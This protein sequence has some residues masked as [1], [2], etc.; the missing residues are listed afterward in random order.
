[1]IGFGVQVR[2]NGRKSFTLDYRFEARRRRLF[3]GDFPDWS[4]VAAREQAKRIKR[5]IDQGAGARSRHL[6]SHET[7]IAGQILSPISKIVRRHEYHWKRDAHSVVH[8]NSESYVARAGKKRGH[9]RRTALCSQVQ[10]SLECSAQEL[11]LRDTQGAN[12][13]VRGN[14]GVAHAIV[15]CMKDEPLYLISLSLIRCL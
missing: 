2:G 8:S 6:R 14:V 12:M 11:R 1:V 13:T 7:G 5:D 9:V 4:T 10:R 3:I 15:V